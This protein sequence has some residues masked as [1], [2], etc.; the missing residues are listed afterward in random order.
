[1]NN[2]KPPFPEE[3]CFSNS[4]KL[5][6]SHESSRETLSVE[7]KMEIKQIN[8]VQQCETSNAIQ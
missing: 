6:H 8:R 5:I 2:E 3:L 4:L 7:K 1:M